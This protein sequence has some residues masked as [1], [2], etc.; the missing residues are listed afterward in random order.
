MELKKNIPLIVGISIPFLMIL[1][2]AASIY[3]PSLFYQPKFDFLYVTGE[4]YFREYSFLVQNGKLI[5]REIEHKE[6]YLPKGEAKLFLHDI[7]KNESREIFYKEAQ[8]L[9]LDSNNKS[10]DGFEVVYGT[11]E[12]GIFPFIFS[13]RDYKAIYIKGHNVSKKLE[14]QLSG[15]YYRNFRFLGWIIK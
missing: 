4:G 9:K 3:L 10:P 1:F 15:D 7:V 6:D 5:K 8:E 13:G 11:R 14:V 2:V 12:S